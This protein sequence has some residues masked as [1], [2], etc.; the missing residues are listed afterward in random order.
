M[1]LEEIKKMIEALAK[2]M[3][4]FKAENDKRISALEK[5]SGSD[6]SIDAKIKE[7][8]DGYETTIKALKEQMD[9]LETALAT[10][11]GPGGSIVIPDQPIY[12]G[13][14]A[15]ALGMQAMDI[16]LVGQSST[17]HNIRS[18]A[19]QRL[20]HNTKR[21]LA[22]LEKGQGTVSREFEAAS[23]RPIHGAA[24]TG[25]TMDGPG[26]EGGFLLQSE[27]SMDLMT[28]SFNN[29]EVTR[30]CSK[31]TITGSDSLEII[32]IDETSRADGSRGGG[33][34]VYTDAELDQYTSSNTKLAKIKVEPERLTGLCF[35]TDKLLKNAVFLGQ[36][37]N[38]LFREEFQFKVQDI[39]FN[40]NGAGMGL[41]ITVADC[42][43]AIAAES[44]QLA[45]TIVTENILKMFARWLPLGM[46]DSLAWFANR[47]TFVQL[48]TL[49]YDIGTGGELA[50]LFIPP[51]MP[52]GNGS[53]LGLPVVFIEQ[54]Q[55]LGTKGD[56]VLADMSQYV[57]ADYGNI[58]EASSVHLKFD[59]GQTTFRFTYYFDGQPRWKSALTPYKGTGDTVGPFVS[60]AT[61][62]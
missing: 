23:M 61:R 42:L 16:Y 35:V 11:Q 41:G 36:E 20:E 13:S 56:I 46:N 57:A 18:D 32:G 14:K 1:N 8:S 22:L 50:R 53:M 54:A 29:G 4:D 19:M 31:R 10:M 24:G 27:T 51:T 44:G 45:G 26:S 5:K 6:P 30:R 40:G 39:I 47:N 9:A 3:E 2:A 49:T 58:D 37:L 59:Y 48:F 33:I 12:K 34:R 15:A 38:Q 43:V 52:G 60:I 7:I 25:M 28:N 62:S 17:A 21:C 55:S